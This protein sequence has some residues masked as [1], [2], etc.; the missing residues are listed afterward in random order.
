MLHRL[1]LWGAEEYGPVLKKGGKARR[2]DYAR[3]VVSRLWEL[4]CC[5]ECAARAVWGG[6]SGRQTRAVRRIAAAYTY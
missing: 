6:R 3:V 1:G 4:R 5:R 2:M